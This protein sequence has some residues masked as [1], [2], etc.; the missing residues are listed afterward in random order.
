MI[1]QNIATSW[2]ALAAFFVGLG[3][4]PVTLAIG[5]KSRE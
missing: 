1:L 3:T 5:M 2:P 4:I